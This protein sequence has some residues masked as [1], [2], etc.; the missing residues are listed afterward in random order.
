MS[1][2]NA[3]DFVA[4]EKCL[5]RFGEK[6]LFTCRQQDLCRSNICH[7]TIMSLLIHLQV[8]PSYQ[9]RMI[10]SRVYEERKA[11]LS[12]PPLLLY[13]SYCFI[14]KEVKDLD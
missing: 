3:P 4:R 6:Y 1:P 10:L 8:I 13:H 5:K 7:I 9:N 14:K 2:S 11:R 12:P